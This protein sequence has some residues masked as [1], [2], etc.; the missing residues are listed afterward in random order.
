M[1]KKD[2]HRSLNERSLDIACEDCD[3]EACIQQIEE[4]ES[5][6]ISISI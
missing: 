3:G 6:L 5:I 4:S 1:N 2:V